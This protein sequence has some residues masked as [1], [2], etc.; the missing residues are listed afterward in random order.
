LIYKNHAKIAGILLLV[1]IISGCG[2]INTSSYPI[3]AEFAKDARL[4]LPEHLPDVSLSIIKTAEWRSLEAF[5]YSGGSW[6][7]TRVGAHSVILVRHPLGTILFDSGLGRNISEQFLESMP[8][9]LKPFMTY[10]N[11]HPAKDLLEN[12]IEDIPVGI[13]VLSHLHWDHVSGIEDFQNIEVWTTKEEYEWAMEPGTPEGPYITSQRARDDVTWRFISFESGPYENFDESLDI[14]QDGS[15]VLVPL[16]GHGPGAIGMFVSLSS[17]KRLLF[18]GDTT[19]T[20]EGFQMPAHKFW[21][22]SLLADYDREKIEQSILKVYRLMQEYPEMLIVPAHD[23]KIQS[24]IGFFPK[25]I[26]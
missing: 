7:T 9:W 14:F 16:P 20:L 26:R 22:S 1:L 18:T 5:L 10:E 13:I 21:A 4:Q 19:W 2:V 11:H 3:D 17:G 12:E 23:D 8:F 6:T 25:F 15:V 24:T